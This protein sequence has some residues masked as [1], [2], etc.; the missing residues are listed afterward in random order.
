M[1]MTDIDTLVIGL[2]QVEAV[3][4]VARATYTH[5]GERYYYNQKSANAGNTLSSHCANARV[6]QRCA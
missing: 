5:Q 1:V 4:L 2:K 6:A 3:I